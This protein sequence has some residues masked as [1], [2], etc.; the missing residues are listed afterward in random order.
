MASASDS[1]LSND[2]DDDEIRK[3]FICWEGESHDQ[4]IQPCRCKPDGLKYVHP[5]CIELWL[6][7]QS[8]L[9]STFPAQRP[10]TTSSCCLS[11]LQRLTHPYTFT[12]STVVS[13]QPSSYDETIPRCAVCCSPYSLAYRRISI[14]EFIMENKFLVGILILEIIVPILIYLGICMMGNGLNKLEA[15]SSAESLAPQLYDHVT[16]LECLVNEQPQLRALASTQKR[17]LVNGLS[18]F[19]SPPVLANGLEYNTVTIIRFID[20]GNWV[21]GQRRGE[22]TQ[23][24]TRSRFLFMLLKKAILHSGLTNQ[25]RQQSGVVSGATRVNDVAGMPYITRWKSLV[26]SS[27]NLITQL[28]PTMRYISRESNGR[29]GYMKPVKLLPLRTSLTSVFIT[30]DAQ[31]LYDAVIGPV[32]REHHNIQ[33]SMMV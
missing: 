1:L 23:V 6:E 12:R 10:H 5:Q 31:S 30:Y 32:R 27:N 20:C 19:F 4:L 22:L 7:S 15:S 26:G 16:L 9:Q 33:L 21:Q 18:W 25:V 14:R 24:V 8:R 28:L 3:C 11:Y 29:H 13:T 2:Y 17:K